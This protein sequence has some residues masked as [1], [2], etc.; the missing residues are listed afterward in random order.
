MDDIETA[1]DWAKKAK[2]FFELDKN[3]AQHDAEIKFIDEYVSELQTRIENN[4]LINMQM[5]LTDIQ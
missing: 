2:D 1:L 3:K 4:N 5:G